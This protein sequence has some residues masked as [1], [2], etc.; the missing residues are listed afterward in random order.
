MNFD[1]KDKVVWLVGGSAGI[2][3]SLAFDLLEQGAIVCVSARSLDGLQ[4]L[5]TEAKTD[6]LHTYSMDVT[7]PEAV[8]SAAWAI[9]A[10]VGA[11]DMLIC[12]AGIYEPVAGPDF[13]GADALRVLDVNLG[14]VVR[15]VDAVLPGMIKRK[16]GTIVGVASVVGYRGLPKAAS[17]GASKAGMINLLESLRFDLEHLGIQVSIVNP[18]FV[19]TR[20]TDKND[21]PMPFRIEAAEAAKRI[22]AGLKSGKKEIHF[23]K[24][25]S[26]FLKFLRVLPYPVYEF[27]VRRQA[28]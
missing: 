20:L 13:C 11:I 24:R 19:K 1:F 4:S 15:C 12:N 18:G 6:R 17:Y 3:R 28:V 7:N 21:F 8:Q 16:Q 10:E 23:P 2:G 9:S 27:L 25:F 5:A 22:V 14:G 26:M